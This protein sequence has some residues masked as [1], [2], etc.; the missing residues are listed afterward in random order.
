MSIDAKSLLIRAL[1][2]RVDGL[3]KALAKEEQIVADYAA[4]CRQLR[5]ENTIYRARIWMLEDIGPQK[6]DA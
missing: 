6:L 4:I 1:E 5:T 3:E 2:S